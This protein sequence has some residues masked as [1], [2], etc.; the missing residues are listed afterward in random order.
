MNIREGDVRDRDAI[1]ALRRAA[2]PRDDV[3][4]QRADFWHWQYDRGRIFVA[5][6]GGRVVGHL[7]FVPFRDVMLACDAMVD[8]AMQGL[9]IFSTLA[10]TATEA[11]RRDV[12]VVTAFQIREAVL[13]A[14][15]RAG[16]AEVLQAPIV[17]RPTFAWPRRKIEARRDAIRG[18]WQEWRFNRNPAWRYA[19]WRDER[20]F[21]V[22]RDA[23]LKG[24]VTHCLVD[25]GG[26]PRAVIRES[27]GDARRRGVLLTAALVSRAHPCFGALRKCGYVAG[28]H[29]F[30]FLVHGDASPNWALTWA[31]T[32]HV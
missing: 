18:Q 29:R 9:G 15:M 17:L 21:V 7:G 1:L 2:F 30:R 6:E 31:A 10:K 8:P 16:Y 28:P 11:V 32:D 13:P 3:E 12:P 20:G 5:E 22:T 14:M 24:F 23:V 26:D 27:I 25:F 19:E 4:K